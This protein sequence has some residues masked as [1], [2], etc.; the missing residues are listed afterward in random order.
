[1]IYS[2]ASKFIDNVSESGKFVDGNYIPPPEI[3]ICTDLRV[4]TIGDFKYD[5]RCQCVEEMWAS[6]M[7][8]YAKYL[9][10]QEYK[11]KVRATLES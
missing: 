11:E 7:F 6:C 10:A 8:H 3:I 2:D 9:G 1:M 4:V 5:Y